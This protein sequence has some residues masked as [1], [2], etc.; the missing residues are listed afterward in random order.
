MTG[1]GTARGR[2]SMGSMKEAEMNR[3]WQAVGKGHF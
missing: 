2:W 3:G 1:V